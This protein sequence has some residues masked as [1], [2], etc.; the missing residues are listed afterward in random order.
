MKAIVKTYRT[1]IVSLLACILT[2]LLVLSFLSTSEITY[3]AQGEKTIFLSDS[4]LLN[5]CAVMITVLIVKLIG[6]NRNVRQAVRAF[7]EDPHLFPMTAALILLISASLGLL[8][9]V[10]VQAEP[11]A[12]QLYIMQA[13]EQISHGDLSAFEDGGYLQ[14]YHHQLGSVT[15][16][17]LLGRLFGSGNWMAFQACNTGALLLVEYALM[18]M[19]RLQG[20]GKIS[21]LFTGLLCILFVPL[22]MYVTFVYGTLWG[23]ALSLLGYVHA[24]AFFQKGKGIHLFLGGLETGLGFFLKSNY[25]IFAI[26]LALTGIL[27][28]LHAKKGKPLLVTLG[29]IAFTAAFLSANVLTFRLVNRSRYDSGIPNSAYI[30]MG[31]AENSLRADGWYDAGYITGLY[32]ETDGDPQSMQEIS[33][34]RLQDHLNGFRKNPQKLF[35]FLLNKTASQWN[36]PTFQGLWIAQVHNHAESSFLTDR[37]EDAFYAYLNLLMPVIQAGALVCLIRKRQEMTPADLLAGLTVVGGF[38]FHLFWEGKCQYTL[39]YFVLLF[40]YTVRGYASLMEKGKHVFRKDGRIL[41]V[42]LVLA[43]VTVILPGNLRRFEAVRSGHMSEETG[44][45]LPDS[46]HTHRGGR[47]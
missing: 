29:T 44:Q 9:I 41:L 46:I 45:M 2:G 21:S 34:E 40:P 27:Q 30:A 14:M 7:N 4:I 11:G 8:W 20:G 19:V 22:G 32:R 36:N 18:K 38:T 6:K 1:L 35:D 47:K 12:D 10:S 24:L 25:L 16:L 5:L 31:T 33:M 26:A 28:A 17:I 39:P 13:A 23:L 37:S 15:A 3:A 43:L 42:P